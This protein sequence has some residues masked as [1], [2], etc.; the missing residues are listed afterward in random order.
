MRWRTRIVAAVVCIAAL[1]L[2]LAGCG[3]S[4]NSPSNADPATVAPGGSIIYVEATV[5]PQGS[6]RSDAQTALTKLLGRNP[7]PQI[8]NGLQRAF[9]SAGLNYQKDI[10]PWLGQ[11]IGFVVTALSSTG[12]GLIM[13]TNNTSAALSALQ[14]AARNDHLSARSYRGVNY[15]EGTDSSGKPEA[16]GIVGHNAVVGGP[17]AFTAIIDASHGGSLASNQ[18]FSSTLSALDSG[19]LLRGYVSGPELASALTPLLSS[20]PN[21][22]AAQLGSLASKLRSAIGFGLSTTPNTVS[23]R[24]HLN[25]TRPSAKPGPDVGG[26]PGQSWLALATGSL[27]GSS[28][29]ALAGLQ[30]GPAAAAL[31]TFRQRFGIDLVR[32]VVP[33][34]G[35]LQLSIQGVAPIS[36]GAGLTVIPANLAAAGRVLGAIYSR[37]AQ[38]PSLTV[39]GSPSAFTITKPGSPIP[40]VQVAQQGHRVI[41][42]LDEPFGTLLSPSS[43]LSQNSRFQRAKSSLNGDSRI[44]LFL[45]LT[46]LS[47][48]TAQIPSFQSGGNNNK[49]QVVLQRL[50]YFVIGDNSTAQDIRAV[51]GLR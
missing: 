35:P 37:V 7:A 40:R 15:Q 42:V 22:N 23:F 24:I 19:S 8:Q 4:S 3:S 2:V 39:H 34:L 1:A 18:T 50:D 27:A 38:D 9:Q 25:G 49:E 31:A 14:K 46:T 11:R 44:P 5:R 17:G 29:A 20:I 26:L 21:L 16:I 48:L 30:S 51:L 47:S 41:A 6:Q 33:A 32:D 13:P 28:P 45:D 43:T 10:Q 12:I 36:I